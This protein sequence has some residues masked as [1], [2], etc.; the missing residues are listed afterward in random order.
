MKLGKN[1]CERVFK[2]LRDGLYFVDR[3]RVITYWNK[4]AERISGFSTEEVFGKAC[5]DSILTHSPLPG[6]LARRV[7]F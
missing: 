6:I 2:N 5:A 1:F 7:D 3:D 4:S